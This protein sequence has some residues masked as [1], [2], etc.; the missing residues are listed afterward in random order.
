MKSYNK[1]F[2]LNSLDIQKLNNT[3][4]GLLKAFKDRKSYGKLANKYGYIYNFFSGNIHLLS[5]IDKLIPI[6]KKNIL[7]YILIVF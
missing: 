3:N 4:K 2:G 7:I 5:Q 6:M 1:Q